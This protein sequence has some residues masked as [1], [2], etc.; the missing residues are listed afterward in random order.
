MAFQLCMLKVFL[1]LVLLVGVP[2]FVAAII[3]EWIDKPDEW[4]D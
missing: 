1:A 2:W 3:Q 4:S